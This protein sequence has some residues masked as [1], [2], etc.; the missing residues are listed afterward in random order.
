MGRFRT[1]RPL[2]LRALDAVVGFALER[3]I[4]IFGLFFG[5]HRSIPGF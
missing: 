2:G 3:L 1:A 4:L 5:A